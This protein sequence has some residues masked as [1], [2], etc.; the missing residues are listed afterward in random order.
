[1]KFS[2]Q[3]KKLYLTPR[4]EVSVEK[5]WNLESLL[6]AVISTII[7]ELDIIHSS[8]V[9]NNKIFKEAK[10]LSYRLSEAYNNFGITAFSIGASYGKSAS[11]TQPTFVPATTLGFHLEDL[12]KLA[13]KLGYKN[14]ILIQLNNLDVNVVHSEEQLAYLLNA[15]RDYFQIA[16][17]SWF[18]V[19]DVGLRAFIAKHVDRLDDLISSDVFIKPLGK[20]YYHQ[21]IK[22]RLDHYKLKKSIEFPI[23]QDVF[24]YLY[25][26]A[27]GRL[28]YIFALVY[29]LIQH[30]QLGKLLQKVSTNLAK[31]TIAA[32]ALARVGKFSLKKGEETL[33]KLIVNNGEINVAKLAELAGRNRVF[34]SRT[35]NKLLDE[36]LVVVRQEG[37]KRMYSA[38]LDAKIA[39]KNRA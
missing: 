4:D 33:L 28:R 11:V 10:A 19:G 6:T 3:A 30:L 1:M 14:G 17:V 12:A 8:S 24:D 21:L 38:S 20:M 23:N 15:A 22:K 37:T 16:N 29:M 13:V 35:I 18:F 39:F 25:E 7:R 26:V 31:D 36:K 27:D 34:V 2:A 32:L 9:K 5:H